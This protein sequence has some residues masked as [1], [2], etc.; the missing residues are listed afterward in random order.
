M[1]NFVALFR[2]VSSYLKRTHKSNTSKGPRRDDTMT[3]GRTRAQG[4]P[5]RIA[6]NDRPEEAAPRNAKRQPGRPARSANQKRTGR[7]PR[8]VS[9]GPQKAPEGDEKKRP[10]K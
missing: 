2:R 4:T 10:N 7:R 8:V 3:E 9:E 1:T 5:A 6:E